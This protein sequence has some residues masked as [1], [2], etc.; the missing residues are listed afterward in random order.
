MCYIYCGVSRVYRDQIGY[1]GSLWGAYRVCIGCVHICI[2]VLG[3]LR[4]SR[5]NIRY[6]GVWC[7]C[8]KGTRRL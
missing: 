4:V 5:L 3:V 1:I 7:I 8:L 6:I 2:Y